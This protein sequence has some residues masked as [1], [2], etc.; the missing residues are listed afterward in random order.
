MV[1]SRDQEGKICPQ[2]APKAPVDTQLKAKRQ[3]KQS[4]KAVVHRM[5]QLGRTFSTDESLAMKTGGQQQS[6]PSSIAR[7]TVTSN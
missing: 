6:D 3:A 2:V 4:G 7:T 1:A 5:K